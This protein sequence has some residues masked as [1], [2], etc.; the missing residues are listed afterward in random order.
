MVSEL[1]YGNDKFYDLSTTIS[2]GQTDS[3][4]IDLSGLELVG[5]F[6][7]SNFTATSISIQAAPAINGTYVQAQDGY[8]SNY[9][10]SVA[11]GKYVPINNFNII[12]GLR[13]IKLTAGAAQA[14]TDALITLAIRSL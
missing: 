7:P 3:G 14:S 9:S 1:S 12:A 13:F 5:L 11:A 2:V 10:L 6:I 8:G 4:V